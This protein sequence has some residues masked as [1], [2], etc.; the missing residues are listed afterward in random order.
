MAARRSYGAG[1]LW[2]RLDKGGSATWYAEWHSHGRRVRRKVGPARREGGRDG[3]T[4]A[5][6]EAEMRRLMAETI[7]TRAPGPRLSVEVVAAR[8]VAHLEAAGRKPSTLAAVRGHLQ[9]WVLPFLGDQA[10]DKIRVDDVRELVRRMKTG[11]RSSKLA[12][13]R[14]RES[15]V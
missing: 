13:G 10:I 5:Q 11:Q 9:H 8:Y 6:A 2:E 4:R 7:V 3:F 12:A 14:W 1:S 15:S